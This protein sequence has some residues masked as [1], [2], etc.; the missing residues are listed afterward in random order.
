MFVHTKATVTS[1]SLFIARLVKEKWSLWR[2]GAIRNK[3]FF[4][5]YICSEELIKY[6]FLLAFSPRE[7]EED[8]VYLE[9]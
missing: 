6:C 7:E 4:V 5:V 8:G 2:T 9:Y 3:S 1:A